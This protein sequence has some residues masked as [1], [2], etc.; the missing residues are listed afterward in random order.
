MNMKIITSLIFFLAVCAFPVSSQYHWN[1]ENGC[2]YCLYGALVNG[3]CV[4]TSRQPYVYTHKSENPIVY[5]Y[6]KFKIR[7]L[8]GNFFLVEYPYQSTFHVF[9]ENSKNYCKTIN[10]SM[11]VKLMPSLKERKKF[12]REQSKRKENMGMFYSMPIYHEDVEFLCD[13]VKFNYKKSFL[14]VLGSGT[15]PV[16][17]KGGL[18]ERFRTNMFHFY[19]LYITKQKKFKIIKEELFSQTFD[20]QMH[21]TRSFLMKDFFT[22]GEC[23]N[24]NCEILNYVE[25]QPQDFDIKCDFIKKKDGQI[26]KV[27]VLGEGVCPIEITDKDDKKQIFYVRSVKDSNGYKLL[28]TNKRK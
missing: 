19:N 27:Q 3:K 10:D 28:M 22:L 16:R 24:S 20:Y 26:G 4:H 6:F 13:F 25:E 15:C 21:N 2:S 23:S 11:T 8:N 7:E 1:D 12:C 18:E 17:V 5:Y 14:E 9:C